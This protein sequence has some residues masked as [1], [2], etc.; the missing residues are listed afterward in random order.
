MEYNGEE[1]PRIY[2]VA[3]AR[4]TFK[5]ECQPGKVRVTWR[6][7]QCNQEGVIM[8]NYTKDNKVRGSRYFTWWQLEKMFD[9]T[10]VEGGG[11]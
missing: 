6:I 9:V 4:F 11:Q 5:D 1:R 2:D 7:S 10:E 8:Q 3:K